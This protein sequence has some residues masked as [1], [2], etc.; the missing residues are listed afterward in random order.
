MLGKNVYVIKG[1]E[2]KEAVHIISFPKPQPYPFVG[3]LQF[4]QNSYL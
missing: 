1:Q 3:I 4:Q 2:I